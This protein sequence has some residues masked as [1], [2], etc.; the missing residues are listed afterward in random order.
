MINFEERRLEMHAKMEAIPG[1]RKVYF[2]PPDSEQMVYP[3]I[4]YSLNGGTHSYSGDYTYMYHP[5]YSVIVIDPDPT[6]QIPFDLVQA[7]PMIQADR[8]YTSN[9]LNHSVYTLYY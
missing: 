3:C 2:Q 5:R 7:F 6:S 9:N 4:R 8:N 1:V